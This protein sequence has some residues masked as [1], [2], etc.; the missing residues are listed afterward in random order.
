MRNG[1]LIDTQD[2]SVPQG[3][4]YGGTASGGNSA[5]QATGGGLG[6][7]AFGTGA[8]GGLPNMFQTGLGYPTAFGWPG[9]TSW[10]SFGPP[11]DHGL[12]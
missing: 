1:F 4:W 9:A 5:E 6:R 8:Q 12:M 11:A 2:A 3:L 7:V 10:V